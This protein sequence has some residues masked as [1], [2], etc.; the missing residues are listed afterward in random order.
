MANAKFNNS[1]ISEEGFIFSFNSIIYYFSDDDLRGR[2]K[3]AYFRLFKFTL[4]FPKQTIKN[5]CLF[6]SSSREDRLSTRVFNIISLL[7]GIDLDK[8][9][10][11]KT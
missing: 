2:L 5:I 4:P 10:L 1:L 3:S 11:Q 7:A 6:F 9:T 8:N